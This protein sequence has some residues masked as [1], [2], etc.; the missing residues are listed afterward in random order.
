MLSLLSGCWH[1]VEGDEADEDDHQRHK[2]ETR[3]L[4]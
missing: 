3:E 2:V 1:G 4:R